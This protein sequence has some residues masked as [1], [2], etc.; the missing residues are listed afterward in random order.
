MMERGPLEGIVFLHGELI[1]DG[2][3]LDASSGCLPDAKYL[4]ASIIASM[5][6]GMKRI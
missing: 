2:Q 3:E 1:D 6:F 5:F 4:H